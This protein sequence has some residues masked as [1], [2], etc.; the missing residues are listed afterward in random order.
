MSVSV[1]TLRSRKL[2]RLESYYFL[3]RLLDSW[4]SFDVGFGMQI[5][6][7]LAQRKWAKPKHIYFIYPLLVEVYTRYS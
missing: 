5:L 3:K 6:E 2:H 4:A 7:V 1:W